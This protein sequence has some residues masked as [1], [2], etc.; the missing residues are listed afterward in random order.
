MSDSKSLGVFSLAMISVAAV[1]SVRNFPSMAVYGWASIGWYV[2]GTLLFLL[3]IT[4]ASAELATGWSKGGGVYLWVKEAFGERAGFIAVFCEWSNN[5]VWFPAVLSFIAGTFAFAINPDL[6]NNGLY[7]FCAMMVAFWGSTLVAWLGPKMTANFNNFGVVIGSF[8]PTA[9]LIALALLFVAQGNPL[10]LGAFSIPALLPDVTLE[11][12]PFVATIVLMFAGMEMAGFHALAVK[13]PGRRFPSAM[14]LAATL[15][16][17]ISVLGTL[18]LAFVIPVAQLNLAAGVMQAFEAFLTKFGVQWLVPVAAVLLSV[19]GLALLISW[20]VGP[21]L[22]LGVTS[23]AGDMPPV[24]RRLNKEGVPTGMLLIQGAIA[25]GFSLLYVFAPSVNAAYWILSAM[26]VLLLCITYLLVFA[27]VIRLRYIKPDVPRAYRIP[28]GLPG[29][30]IVGGVGFLATA[31]AFV[32]GCLPTADAG[33][34][35]PVY[36]LV[37]LGGTALLSIIPVLLILRFRKPSWV[38]TPDELKALGVE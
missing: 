21:V 14:A 31:F 15:I 2:L 18:A 36:V 32:V 25:T 16:F 34:P 37:M 9:L 38:A 5:L 7:M 26:T 13:D 35:L 20:L 10:Q 8:V 22:G 28:G 3:P 30:W 17:V 11:T 6:A 4:L 12:I 27:A 24:T 23:A 19:G 29:V 33:M 1:L